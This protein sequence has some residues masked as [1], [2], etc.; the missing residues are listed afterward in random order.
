MHSDCSYL[1]GTWFPTRQ[2]RLCQPF[3]FES[4]EP[5]LRIRHL[6]I[7]GLARLRSLCVTIVYIN[8]KKELS[9]KGGALLVLASE[10]RRKL[11]WLVARLI[12]L[13]GCW[14]V[15]RSMARLVALTD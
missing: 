2:A 12:A 5:S 4:L 6:Y 10:F 1:V 3:S 11:S 7:E 13:L 9:F 8:K 15:A 14:F